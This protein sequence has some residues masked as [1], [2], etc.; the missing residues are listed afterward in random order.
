MQPENSE[1][2]I[3]YFDQIAKNRKGKKRRH[4]FYWKEISRYCNYFSHEDLSILEIGCGTGNHTVELAKKVSQVL[5]LD[6]DPQMV[7]LAKDKIEKQLSRK[8]MQCHI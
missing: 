5:A 7:A 3:L 2:K 6:I 1:Q 4:A 8:L